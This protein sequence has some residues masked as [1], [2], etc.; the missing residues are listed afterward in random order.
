MTTRRLLSEKY[1]SALNVIG[2]VFGIACFIVLA[3]YL[4]HELTYDQHHELH[5]RIYRINHE[6]DFGTVRN[7]DA[8]SSKYLA[9]MLQRDYPGIENYV[10]FEP[11]YTQSATLFES[12]DDSDFVSDVYISSNSAFEVFTHDVVFGNPE[13]ALVRPYTIAINQT[14]AQRFFG[15]SNP[16][17]EILSSGD[18]DYLVTL[19]F[20]DLPDNSHLKYSA[21]LTLTGAPPD[22]SEESGFMVAR[23]WNPSSFNYLLVSEGYEAPGLG[24]EAFGDL[25]DRVM[26]PIT[27]AGYRAS[28]YL[29]PLADIHLNSFTNNDQPRGNPYY[30]YAFTLVAVFV[31]VIAC[32]NYINLATARATRR[33]SEISIRKLLGANR[34]LLVT[35]FLFES[36]AFA[37]IALLVAVT[38]VEFFLSGN[39]EVNLFGKDLSLGFFQDPIVFVS[40]VALG[41]FV[42]VAAGVY[43]AFVLAMTDPQNRHSKGV[44]RSAGTTVRKCLVLFQFTISM[45]VISATVLM[46][47]QMRY[48]NE[49]PLGYDK[50]NKIA[51]QVQS[52]QTIERIQSFIEQL[53]SNPRIDDASLI[54][55]NPFTTWSNSALDAHLDDGTTYNLDFHGTQVDE[56]F[57][58]L[59]GINLIA[60]RVFDGGPQQS[61]FEAILSRTAVEEIGWDDPIGKT[62]NTTAATPFTVVGVAEDFHFEALHKEIGPF[63]FFPDVIDYENSAPD[64]RANVTRELFLD[65][66]ADSLNE[67]IRFIEQ[68][69][70]VFEPSFPFRYSILEE[71]LEQLYQSDRQQM[72]LIGLFAA[73]SLLISCLGLLGLTA[74]T[75]GQRTKEIG[76]RKTL[77]ASI[78]H[79]FFVLFSNV[80]VLLVVASILAAG[81]S[82]I[83]ITG[84][85][86]NFY[87]RRDIDPLA[88]VYSSFVV[89]VIAIGTMTLQSYKTVSANPIE[90]L[91]Y[92]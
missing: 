42:G 36:I 87:Y 8:K 13:E 10:S 64:L 22:L 35:Q 69:W 70:S 20:A 58:D 24:E 50:F 66:S 19:V 86:D 39:A 51:L 88:F 33:A 37:L 90:A 61:R 26:A 43:P 25:F 80:F 2:L 89:T 67:T 46:L 9:P 17:G 45:A 81:I 55:T 12:A 6:T 4:E 74:F 82:Y 56:N 54:R 63:V 77:G 62:F 60:G 28:F 83:G 23:L 47:L 53:K 44:S 91:R 41:L 65:V 57:F 79:I 85:L 38:A 92:E 34:N 68:Q 40:L 14:V 5:D 76:I 30:L 16:V 31:L 71:D 48:I 73:I 29:E 11:M 75:T 72:L 3:L 1:Y 32:I 15:N 49:R 18:S 78:R 27:R 21:L 59:M 7:R 52:V 84:W